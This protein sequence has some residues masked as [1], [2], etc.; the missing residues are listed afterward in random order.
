MGLLIGVSVGMSV[1]GVIISIM[2]VVGVTLLVMSIVVG[3]SA[4]IVVCDTFASNMHFKAKSCKVVVY[5]VHTL[6]HIFS[7]FKRKCSV[8]NI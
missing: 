1:G 5:E 7:C 6:D 2:S 8:V 4:V 3:A